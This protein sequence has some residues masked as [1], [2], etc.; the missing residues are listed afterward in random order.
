VLRQHDFRL[1]WIGETTSA[2]GTSVSLLAVPLIAVVTLDAGAFQVSLL[3]AIGW[4]PWLVVG[5]PAGAWVDRLPL[6]R[7]MLIANAVCVV[8]LLSVPLATVTGTLHLANLIVVAAVTGTANVF[9]ATSLQV[10]LTTIVPETDLTDANAALHGSESVTGVAG[11]GIA[12]VI[13]QLVGASAGLIADALSFVVSSVGLLLIRAEGT[14][15]PRPA[16]TTTLRQEIRDGLAFVAADP[17]LRVLTVFGA[18]ANVALTGYQA[19]LVVF[20]IRDVGVSSA[21]AGLLLSAMSI[22]GAL[23]A[24]VSRPLSRRLGSA[25]AML[26]SQWAAAPFSL[27]VPLTHSGVA[28]TFVVVGG[29]GIGTG[30]VSSNVIG[31]SF[32]QTYTPRRLL[33]RVVVTMQFLNFG[34]IPLGA[35]LGGVLGTALG[36]RPTLWIMTS[37]VVLSSLILLCG[38]IRRHRDL[39]AAA[40]D[41]VGAPK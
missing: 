31:A 36:L 18:A 14:R 23:G 19:I 9:F 8:A 41:H 13:T 7:T 30:V 34:A 26:L 2:L 21:G 16:R 20:L 40:P 17:Y 32:R 38:P 22:G 39:P 1:L 27:L 29:I 4:L 12:G 3:A 10:Y 25:R 6:R 5:L 33:G 24:F 28:L 15:A 35:L 37:A 11:P